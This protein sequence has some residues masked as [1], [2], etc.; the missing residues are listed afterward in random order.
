M[1]RWYYLKP[2]TAIQSNNDE[3]TNDTFLNAQGNISAIYRT[4]AMYF[5]AMV[6]M[7]LDTTDYVL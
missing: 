4:E 6:N 1:S 5:L 7:V 2:R 3:V